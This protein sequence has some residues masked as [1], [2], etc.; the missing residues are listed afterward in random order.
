M[1]FSKWPGKRGS[2]YSVLLD[3]EQIEYVEVLNPNHK[4]LAVMTT[5]GTVVKVTASVDTFAAWLNGAAAESGEEAPVTG[6][7]KRRTARK[8]PAKAAEETEE[9]KV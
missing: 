8:Q 3:R 6:S 2:N 9:T 7:T 5:G 4:L 1:A